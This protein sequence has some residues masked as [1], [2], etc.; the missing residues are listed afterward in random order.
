MENKYKQ[1]KKSKPVGY[2]STV[3]KIGSAFAAGSAS[4]ITIPAALAYNLAT[5][6]PLMADGKMMEGLYNTGMYTL[7]AG[8]GAAVIGG[9][10]GLLLTAKTTDWI[11]SL[12]QK[13]R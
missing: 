13:R 12:G 9:A 2:F 7:A 1:E 3:D 10:L 6:L 4:L 5:Q 11:S 8:G